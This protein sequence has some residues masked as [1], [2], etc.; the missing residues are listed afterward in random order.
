MCH[1][2]H[3]NWVCPHNSFLPSHNACHSP[4]SPSPSS[5]SSH[6]HSICGPEHMLPGSASTHV[7]IW[8]SASPPRHKHITYEYQHTHTHNPRH[9]KGGQ[10]TTYVCGVCQSQRGISLIS[11]PL[12]SGKPSDGG[13]VPAF[14]CPPS[15]LL[16]AVW[17]F[18]PSDRHDSD[19]TGELVICKHAAE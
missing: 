16:T 5:S 18:L 4:T 15:E 14:T 2:S 19:P 9:L 7:P 1:A 3:V 6:L 10:S 8:D 12:V 13:K 17:S 11:C